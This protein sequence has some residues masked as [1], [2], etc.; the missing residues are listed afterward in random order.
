MHLDKL[1]EIEGMA[2]KL[3]DKFPPLNIGEYTLDFTF[4]DGPKVL[5][6]KKFSLVVFDYHLELLKNQNKGIEAFDFWGPGTN[7]GV[8][9]SFLIAP[10]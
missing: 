2:D 8:P 10:K 5:S 1:T 9:I 7:P 4:Y 6:T 3:Y